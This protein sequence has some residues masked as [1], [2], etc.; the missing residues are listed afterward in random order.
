VKRLIRNAKRNY[1]KKLSHGNGGNSRPFFSYFKRKTKSRPSIGPI[2]NSK[3]ETVSDDQGKT[4]LN[5]FFGSVFTREETNIIP[6]AEEMETGSM[7]DVV[8]KSQNDTRKDQKS[9]R[10]LCCWP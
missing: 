10:D 6:E 7:E 8:I 3:K 1:E 9:E 4:E 5:E 2:K